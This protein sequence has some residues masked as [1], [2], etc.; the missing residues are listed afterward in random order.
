MNRLFMLA[1]LP[2]VRRRTRLAKMVPVLQSLGIRVFFHGW[3]RDKGEAAEWQSDG[4]DERVI[5][6]GGG[7]ASARA[8]LMYPLWMAAVF[9]RVLGLGRKA[10]LFCLGWE[11]AFPALLASYITGAR[12]IF[13]DADRFSLVMKLPGGLNHIVQA[14]EKWTSRKV[15]LHIVPSLS[16][17]EWNGANMVVLRNTPSTAD[18]AKAG[19]VRPDR[20][21]E[22]FTLYANGWVGETR[23]A[24]VFLA[25][26]QRVEASRLPVKMVVAGRV[27][28]KAGRELIAHP[29]V[30]YRGELG[31][32]DALKIYREVDLA[33]TYYDPAVPINRLAESNKW[34]DCVF[35][36]VPFVVNDE[37][38]TANPFISSGAAF[39]LPYHDVDAL[40]VLVARLAKAPD[41]VAA[42]GK[43]LDLFRE[44][45]GPFDRRFGDLMSA[46]LGA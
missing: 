41:E 15:L 5:L 40:F 14:L 43:A 17:Y 38:E 39:S 2:A 6:R 4:L 28:S 19:A 12:I 44:E 37:V 8:R 33:L 24:P 32:V 11:T 21:T 35:F 29:Y 34:G 45:Y 16:R 26:M 10:D 46:A 27:D 13:D 18:Y 20:G 42:H 36:G 31:Q 3:E 30:S 1:P 22:P 23:G 25:L 7:Y 9:F